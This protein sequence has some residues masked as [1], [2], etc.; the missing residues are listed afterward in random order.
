[1]FFWMAFQEEKAIPASIMKLIIS[2]KRN[3][4]FQTSFRLSDFI[5]RPFEVD[6]PWLKAIYFHRGMK[7]KLLE[8]PVIL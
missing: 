2:L 3:Q 4:K 5:L 1:M 6:C 8:G 7:D